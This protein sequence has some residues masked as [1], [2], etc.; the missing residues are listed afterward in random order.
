MGGAKEE[1]TAGGTLSWV[2]H[3]FRRRPWQGIM[4]L[5]GVLA[6]AAALGLVMRS[7]FWGLFAL[8]VLGLSLEAFYFPTRY[9]LGVENLTVVKVFSRAEA[10][11]ARFRRVYE[12]RQG[13]T[14]SPYARRAFLEPYRSVR[15]LFD[16]GAKE[17]ICAAVR[18]RLRPGT[19]WIGPQG[20]GPTGTG[21][22]SIGPTGTG[23]TGTGS[24][25]TGPMGTGPRGTGST[26]TEPTSTEARAGW[27]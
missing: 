15:L 23:S 13:L 4:T 25:G 14:L 5:A 2:A 9:E 1:L 11:W 8:L 27:S 21:T 18:A 16:G 17:A 20:T 19:E 22:T 10:S 6:I 26:G 24:T 7:P 3:P 12:D